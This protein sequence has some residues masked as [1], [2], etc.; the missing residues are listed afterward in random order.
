MKEKI[1]QLVR[2]YNLRIGYRKDKKVLLYSKEMTTQDL[3]FAKKHKYEIL[4]Y[5]EELE[6]KKE[7]ERREKQRKYVEEKYPTELEKAKETGEA[8]AIDQEMVPC[9]DPREECSLDILTR[10]LKVTPDGEYE[11]L[12]KRQH[13]W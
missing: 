2:E 10:Y 6:Q 9:N 12:E 1:L 8:I 3:E 13:T 5:L 11:I 4:A 7:E